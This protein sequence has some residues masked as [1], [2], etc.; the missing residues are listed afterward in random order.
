MKNK[1]LNRIYMSDLHYD[2]R[3][4]VKDIFDISSEEIKSS[5]GEIY[6]DIA[7]RNGYEIIKIDFF[8]NQISLIISAQVTTAPID[9]VRSIKSFSTIELLDRHPRLKKIYA[10][11]GSFWEGGYKIS[12][13]WM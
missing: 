8:E 1:D 2:I 7:K 12:T 10:T 13:V 6:K 5:L 11:N 4:G 9:I 3:F